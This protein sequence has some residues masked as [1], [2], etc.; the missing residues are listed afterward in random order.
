MVTDDHQIDYG[1]Y[2]SDFENADDTTK[3]Q[4]LTFVVEDEVYGIEI[5]NIK[6]I[7]SICEITKVPLTEAHIKGIIN[8]RGDII[9]VL[10]IR[11]RFL[12]PAVEYDSLT[13]I[14]V[15]EYDKYTLGLIVDRVNEVMHIEDENILMP[16]SAKL[17]HHNQYIRNIGKSGN[18]VILLLDLDKLLERDL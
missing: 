13:C 3:G 18:N 2:N 15:V 16:P 7:I 6:E 1:M 17:S 14:V 10:D 12:K 11:A 5:S 4:F 8:L 9:P